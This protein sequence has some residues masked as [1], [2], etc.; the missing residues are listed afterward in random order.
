MSTIKYAESKRPFAFSQTQRIA[1]MH[2]GPATGETIMHFSK[3]VFL[4]GAIIAL[5]PPA[6]ATTVKCV[7]LDI[8]NTGKICYDGSSSGVHWSIHC[9]SSSTGVTM[10]GV[11][12]C[13]SSNIGTAGRSLEF[14]PTHSSYNALKNCFCRMLTPVVSWWVASGNFGSTN[15]SCIRDC[16]N[17]CIEAIKNKPEVRNALFTNIL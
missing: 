2:N 15:A 10:S 9:S 4:F 3:G 5:C 16:A 17:Y 1:S 7:R 6:Y 11:A 12:I 14:I 13:S 8:N